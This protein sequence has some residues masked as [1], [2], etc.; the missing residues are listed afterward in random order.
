MKTAFTDTI[1]EK[2]FENSTTMRVVNIADSS[3]R[4]AIKYLLQATVTIKHADE[5]LP[6][7][8]D[9]EIINYWETIKH[10]A[11]ERSTL[12]TAIIYPYFP[13]KRITTTARALV[14]SS[15]TDEEINDTLMQ[16]YID[17]I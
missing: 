2:I 13:G 10:Y 9:P 8:T 15:T 12:F 6:T 16:T 14:T 1:G 17:T 7:A 4:Y 3:V 5:M 11:I